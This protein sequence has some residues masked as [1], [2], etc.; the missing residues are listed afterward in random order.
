MPRRIPG[1][2]AWN[3]FLSRITD[4]QDAVKSSG[5][6]A[7]DLWYRGHSDSR[8]QLLPSLL[9]TETDPNQSTVWSKIWQLESDLFWEF[10][11]RARELQ[12]GVY[13]E[14]D[15]LFAMQH[16]GTPTRL[17]DWTEVLAVAVY[18]A[19]LGID[20]RSRTDERGN[21]SSPPCVWVLNPYGLNRVASNNPNADLVDPRNLG[22]EEAERE[23]YTYSELIQEEELGFEM[24]IAIYPR[25]RNPRIQAQRAWFTI[26]GDDYRPMEDFGGDETYLKK[27]TLPFSALPAARQFLQDAGID[28]YLL[29]ADLESLSLTLR[30]KNRLLTSREAGQI[31]KRRLS[32]RE[33]NRKLPE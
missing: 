21:R 23:Y 32:A 15:F 28:H 7:K 16:Y 1:E 8:Y 29:F 12:A 19:I 22:W 14:W 24:P 13:D 10:S 30:E 5:E 25:Q 11:A 27:V 17:L 18:F 26:H 20:E 2:A 6:E 9:R 31:W 4:A 3:R 33:V